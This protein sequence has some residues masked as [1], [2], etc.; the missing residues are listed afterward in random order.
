MVKWNQ[1]KWITYGKEHINRI[2]VQKIFEIIAG[3]L[4]D[5]KDTLTTVTN[6]FLQ[7]ADYIGKK[8]ENILPTKISYENEM[9]TKTG[10]IK[11]LEKMNTKQISSS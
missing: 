11:N 3:Y 4:T 5:N 2:K 6:D 1:N 8:L 9:G 7:I 10:L